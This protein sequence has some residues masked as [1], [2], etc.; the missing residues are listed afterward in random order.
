MLLR[1]PERQS[2]SLGFGN[3]D[4]LLTLTR[5]TLAEMEVDKGGMRDE[6]GL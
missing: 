4:S 5:E 6:N 3:V 1:V 2:R